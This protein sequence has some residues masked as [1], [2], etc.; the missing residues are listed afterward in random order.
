MATVNFTFQAGEFIRLKFSCGNTPIE[1]IH[2]VANNS[3]SV[4]WWEE[5][6]TQKANAE[7]PYILPSAIV[8]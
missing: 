5:D 2:S 7:M 6:R 1:R 8:V 4:S 3:L